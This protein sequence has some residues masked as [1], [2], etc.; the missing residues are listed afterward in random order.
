M[1]AECSCV[2]TILIL[3][4]ITEILRDEKI[5]F[6][7]CLIHDRF[8]QLNEICTKQR[9]YYL[10]FQVIEMLSILGLLLKEINFEQFFR[11]S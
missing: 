9:K 2:L 5:T 7:L 11:L 1:H 4:Q 3:K 8:I 10:I 6:Q